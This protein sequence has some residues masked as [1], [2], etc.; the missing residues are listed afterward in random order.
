MSQRGSQFL[1][2]IIR[3]IIADYNLRERGVAHS[4]KRAPELVPAIV[5]VEEMRE[6][7]VTQYAGGA[8]KR[9]IHVKAKY[10]PYIQISSI[11]SRRV[12]AGRIQMGE[13]KLTIYLHPEDGRD[14]KLEYPDLNLVV[15]T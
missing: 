12:S 14:Y 13:I 5:G 6:Y 8:L 11:G 7:Q 9:Y 3:N 15:E 4:L 10:R 2:I 1:Y